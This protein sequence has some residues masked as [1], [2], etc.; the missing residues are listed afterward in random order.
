MSNKTDISKFDRAL[1]STAALP[2]EV[3]WFTPDDPAVRFSGAAFRKP[4][5]VY[6]RLPVMEG[7]TEAVDELAWH[8]SGMQVSF[9]TNSSRIR[10]RAILWHEAVFPHLTKVGSSGFDLY[11]GE[12]GNQAFANSVKPPVTADSYDMDLTVNLPRLMREYTINFPLYSGVEAVEFGIDPDAELLPPTPWSDERPL[13]FYGTSITHGGCACRPG[14]SYTTILGRHFN[15]PVI[16]LGFSGSGMGEPIVFQQLA[17]IKNPGIFV[18]DYEANAQPDGIR[19]TLENGIRIIREAH[20]EVPIVVLSGAI[21]NF[22]PLHTDMPY[23]RAPQ[24]DASW[25]FQRGVVERLRN[26]GDR[27]LH[28]ICG[29]WTESPMWRE[30]T[31]DGI[32]PNDMGF[33]AMAEYLI[34]RLEKLL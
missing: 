12:P 31:V 1:A 27:N 23:Q 11:Y 28:F 32:H 19:A 34:P 13:V 14:L 26:A 30:Y 7:F 3:R 6:R 16:N 33:I 20:P 18:L 8:T 17:A 22:E 15:R 24:G 25:R 9:R 5:D 21:F 10:V 4:G 29:A 2:G